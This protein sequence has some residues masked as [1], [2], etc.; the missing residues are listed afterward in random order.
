MQPGMQE[1]VALKQSTP[2]FERVSQ[3]LYHSE[4]HWSLLGSWKI[5]FTDAGHSDTYTPHD[6]GAGPPLTLS[7]SKQNVGTS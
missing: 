4:S 6:A 7:L 3:Q 5:L 2:S 1:V